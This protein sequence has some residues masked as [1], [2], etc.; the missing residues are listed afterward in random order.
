MGNISY[1]GS[2]GSTGDQ[3]EAGENVSG[4]ELVLPRHR[5]IETI[6]NAALFR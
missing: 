2:L 6:F 3:D 4:I 1:H 5:A